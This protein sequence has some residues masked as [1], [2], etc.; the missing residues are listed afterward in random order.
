MSSFTKQVQLSLLP[1]SMYPV[2]ELWAV[3]PKGIT[4]PSFLLIFFFFLNWD[5]GSVELLPRMQD[6]IMAKNWQA[7][8]VV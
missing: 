3:Y 8:V 4:F 2:F 7:K 6:I 5:Y 1:L